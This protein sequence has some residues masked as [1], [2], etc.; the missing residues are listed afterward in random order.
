MKTMHVNQTNAVKIARMIL[1][2]PMVKNRP[3]LAFVKISEWDKLKHKDEVTVFDGADPEISLDSFRD[4]AVVFCNYR[5][6]EE[7]LLED[8]GS[9]WEQELKGEWLRI[10]IG[11][12]NVKT[13]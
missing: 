5:D 8:L 10:A 12:W 2:K 6:D 3:I 4:K 11:E 7:Y 9:M 1:Q 13:V